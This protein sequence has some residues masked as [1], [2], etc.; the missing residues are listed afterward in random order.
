MTTKDISIA[1]PQGKASIAVLNDLHLFKPFNIKKKNAPQW[2]TDYFTSLLVLS[3]KFSFK[4]IMKKN[5][6]LYFDD[7]D[8]YLSLIEPHS[9]KN[10]PYLFFATCCMHEDKSWSISPTDNWE[11]NIHL[12][13]RINDMKKEFFN[14]I[15]TNSPVID[16]L[17]YFAG[18]LPYYQRL[19]ANALANSLKRSLQLSL[20]LNESQSTCGKQLIE[21]IKHVK[22]TTL[23][24]LSQN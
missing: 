7:N 2:L 12:N 24:L 16:T 10:C 11:K 23:G 6:Y 14:S 3:S 21:Q 1:N 9:W 15:N 19:A 22:N 20:G 13:D 8:W 5:Y 18:H 17:P 4:P